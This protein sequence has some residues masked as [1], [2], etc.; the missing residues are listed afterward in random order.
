MHWFET[1]FNFPPEVFQEGQ[2]TFAGRIAAQV[3]ILALPVLILATWFAYR[4]V[5][6]RTAT[7]AWRTVLALR[8]GL[9]VILLFLLADPIMR[10]AHGRAEV[11]TVVLVDT[12]HSMAIPD[13][14]AGPGVPLSR[15]DAARQLLSGDGAGHEGFLKALSRSGK[16][17]VY[18]FDENV[19]RV[20]ATGQLKADGQSTNIFRGIHDMEAELRGMPLAAVVLIT[21]GGRN[22]GGTTQDAAA[23]LADRGVPLYPVGLGN[24][25]PPNDYEVVNVVAPKRVRRDSEVEVQVTVRHTGYTEPFDL[26]VSR[27]QTVISTHKITPNMDTDLEQVKLVFTPDQEGTATYRIAIP[28]GKDE[29]NTDNNFR[30]FDVEIRDDRLPVLY[31]EGSPRMEYRFLRRA[32]YNDP[33]F[34]LVGLLRLG[35]NRF[36][37]QGAN[38]SESFLA[39]G[40]PTTV[41]QLYAF[42]AIILGDIEASYFTSDQ[43]KMLQEF[44]RTRGGGLLM[45]GGV[46]SFGLGNYTGTPIADMLPVQ[47]TANDGPY[48]DAQFK[49]RVMQGIGVHPVMQLSLDPEANRV[50]WSQS[51]PLIG[52][53]P[54]SG[55]KA[56]ALTLLTR[57]SDNK[58]VFA[59]QNYGAGRV[60]AFTSGGS[61]YWRVSVPSTVE[62][63]EKFWKQLV[64]WLA[65]GAKE[66]LTAE[67]ESDVYAR[68]KPVTIRAT[69]LAKDLQPV[70]DASIIATVTDPLGNHEDVPMDWIL[71]E[72]GVYQA[73]YVPQD[74]GDYRVSVRVDGWTD[75]KPVEADFRVAQPTVEAADT[76]LK[77]DELKEMAK[78]AHG[79]YFTFADANQVPDE[80]ARS[81]AGAKFTGIKPEDKE[82]WDMP[83]L[84]VLAFALMVAEWIVRRRC[85]LA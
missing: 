9:V 53:T 69:A 37:V 8:L 11:F 41:E 14:V 81:V 74:E 43:M 67:T 57:E 16:V 32:L 48:S 70:N 49:A 2:L 44:V 80:I 47:I 76:G 77:E 73:Q 61:W 75:T 62:F 65:V 85:G 31:V 63:Y 19:R 29:K 54:V 39:K 72:E 60:A 26:T 51:P 23:I 27:G 13:V 59:V 40:F 35:D 82:I 36:Y 28:A 22:A 10:W 78:I 56:G 7:T 50:L 17:L 25:N 45:L 79:R 5:A 3:L 71:S 33:D 55:V 52:I 83:V 4:L 68:T 34:R 42:Q 64:R 12:S 84:F 1:L 6:Q 21:D 18:G 46:N 24:P 15:I 20:T 58:P 38:D 30:D 66:R